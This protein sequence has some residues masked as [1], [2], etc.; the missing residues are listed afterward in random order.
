MISSE[1]EVV[2]FEASVNP[3]NK[4][5]EVWMT[6]LQTM[7]IQS[8]R[9]QM[10]LGIANYFETKRTDWMQKWP[11]QVVIN[12]SQFQWTRECEELINESGN[13]GVLAYHQTS[14]TCIEYLS[15]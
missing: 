5:I 14:Q 9:H 13:K 8:V 10:E 6:E 2:E 11:G 3:V 15:V 7:M 1:K 12:A 4:S